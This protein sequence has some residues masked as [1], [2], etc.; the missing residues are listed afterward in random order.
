MFV[1]ALRTVGQSDHPRTTEAVRLLVDRLLP[2]GG[3]NYGNTLVLGQELLPHVQPSGVVLWALEG[4]SIDDQRVQ[5]SADYLLQNLG[6]A[7]TAASLAYGVLGLSAV[8]RRPYEADEW[9][10]AAAERELAGRPSFYKLALLSLA[11]S[12]ASIGIAAAGLP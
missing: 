9:L 4:L 6:P 2:S 5:R 1:R 3:A 7:T 12:G 10:R 8:G 11:M